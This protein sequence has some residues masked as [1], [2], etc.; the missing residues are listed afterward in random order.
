MTDTVYNWR[1]CF[2]TLDPRAIPLPHPSWRNNTWLSNNPWFEDDV[3]PV[4]RAEVE[5]I[6][7]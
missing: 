2:E 3:L 7:G 1:E 6:L 5:R 4:V